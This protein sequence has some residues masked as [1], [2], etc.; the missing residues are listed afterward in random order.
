MTRRRIPDADAQALEA[1]Q[2]HRTNA[3]LA[4]RHELHANLITY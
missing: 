1:V 4:A 3:E 2:V